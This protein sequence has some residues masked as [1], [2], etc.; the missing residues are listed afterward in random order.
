MSDYPYQEL[1]QLAQKPPKRLFGYNSRMDNSKDVEGAVGDRPICFTASG[2]IHRLPGSVSDEKR[3]KV[4]D[5]LYDWAKADA[6]PKLNR[7]LKTAGCWIAARNGRKRMVRTLS[8]KKITLNHTN[9]Y[10]AYCI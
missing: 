7:V 5:A 6:L 9:A 3:Q 10:D 1:A 8:D 2:G 4:L